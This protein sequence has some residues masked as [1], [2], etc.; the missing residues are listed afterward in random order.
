MWTLGPM[1]TEVFTRIFVSL[2]GLLAGLIVWSRTVRWLQAVWLKWRRSNS[3]EAPASLPALLALTFLHS[4]PWL[5]VAAA[6]VARY[7]LS[8]ANAEGWAW[9][10]Q[11]AAFTPVLIAVSV[12]LL[13]YRLRKAKKSGNGA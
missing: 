10:F 12:S 6:L 9:F 4:G 8:S 3:G 7:G 5:L 13:M 11:G 1:D 2:G